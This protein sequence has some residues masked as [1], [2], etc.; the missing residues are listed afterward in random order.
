[1]A[2]CHLSAVSDWKDARCFVE[3]VEVAKH[4]PGIKK[5]WVEFLGE[6]PDAATDRVETAPAVR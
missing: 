5:Q 6:K 1:M 4:Y 2:T 3:L